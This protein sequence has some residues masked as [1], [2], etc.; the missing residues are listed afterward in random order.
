MS[1]VL[2][3]ITGEARRKIDVDV[4]PELA[5]I[6]EK[7]HFWE[8]DGVEL[9]ENYWVVDRESG[10]YLMLSPRFFLQL[11]GELY[12]FNFK[13][14]VYRFFVRGDYDPAVNFYTGEKPP[15]GD[16]EEFKRELTEA[17]AVHGQFGSPRFGYVPLVPAF[18]EE[19]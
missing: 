15:K 4:G 16:F 12:F 1:Y 7:R 10:N 14:K 18:P 2:E 6:M 17:F 3:K 8:S 5:R 11:P 19:A 13:S 9:F